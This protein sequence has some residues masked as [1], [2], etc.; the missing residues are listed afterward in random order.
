VVATSAT[1]IVEK[2]ANADEHAGHHHGHAHW[3]ET[4]LPPTE[5]TVERFATTL[6]SHR[7]TGGPR[8]SGDGERP[9]TQTFASH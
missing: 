1:A 7:P 6:Y 8:G 4:L 2:P 9:A 5:L 3:N